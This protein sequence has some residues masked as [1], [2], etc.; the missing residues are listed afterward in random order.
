MTIVIDENIPNRTIKALAGQQHDLIVMANSSE[1][2]ASDERVWMI[3][4]QAQGLL[5]TT[6]KG[7][8]R[9]PSPHSG[10]LVIRLRQPNTERIHERVMYAMGHFAQSSWP[11]QVV[12][13]RDQTMSVRRN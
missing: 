10:I 7:F 12:V 5:I 6:D 4:Q 11:N 9:R 2:G 8:V 1:K 13:I 3:A